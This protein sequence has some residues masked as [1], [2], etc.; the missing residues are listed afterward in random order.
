MARVAVPA[1]KPFSLAELSFCL[2]DHRGNA[3]KK[4]S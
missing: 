4:Q 3:H 2:L 1:Q